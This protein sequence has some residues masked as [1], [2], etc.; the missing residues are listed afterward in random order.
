MN[1][2]KE[3]KT[4]SGKQLRQW[5][6]MA[7]SQASQTPG[8]GP[9]S[10][11]EATGQVCSAT[12]RKCKVILIWANARFMK[13][14]L[15]LAGSWIFCLHWDL[16][17]QGWQCPL[18]VV[19]S[20]CSAS[21]QPLPLLLARK[22]CPF[23]VNNLSTSAKCPLLLCVFCASPPGGHLPIRE[24]WEV[25]DLRSAPG[26]RLYS[27]PVYPK[28]NHPCY[29]QEITPKVF[30]TARRKS[31]FS[32]HQFIR[33]WEMRYYEKWWAS[34]LGRL[35]KPTR[36]QTAADT[37]NPVSVYTTFWTFSWTTGSKHVQQICIWTHCIFLQGPAVNH[38]RIAAYLPSWLGTVSLCPL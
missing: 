20:T 32:C 27:F 4:K 37:M 35:L 28:Q 26:A 15:P 36:T 10:F 13:T 1:T 6:W 22:S 14:S 31:F 2:K 33:C 25:W 9:N 18:V 7:V 12:E 38:N 11:Q 24:H 21:K 23:F 30:I 19:T 17:Q 8:P 34:G 3:R 5:A 29:V 16:W